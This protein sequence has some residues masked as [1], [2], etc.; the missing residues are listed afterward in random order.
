VSVKRDAVHFSLALFFYF[1]THFLE[2]GLVAVASL[3]SNY[4]RKGRI[5]IR[6]GSILILPAEPFIWEMSDCLY[7]FFWKGKSTNTNRDRQG[8]EFVDNDI[9]IFI[10]LADWTEKR[11]STHG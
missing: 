7:F 1:F 4:P 3:F 8:Q 9:P 6:D 10:G 11:G 5:K 2:E